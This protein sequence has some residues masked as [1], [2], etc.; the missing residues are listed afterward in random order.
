MSKLKKQYSEPKIY[1]AGGDLTKRWYVY[2]SFRNPETG[3]LERQPTVELGINSFTT[4]KDREEAIILLRKALSYVLKSGQYNPFLKTTPGSSDLVEIISTNKIYTI[5]DAVKFSL[6]IKENTLSENSYSDYRIRVKQFEKWLITNGYEKEPITAIS[7][8]VVTSFLNELL[9]KTSPKNRNNTRAAISQLYG[10]LEDN[11]I[12]PENFITKI[13]V[14]KSKPKRNKTYTT[15]QETAI[16]SEMQKT[17]ELLLLFIKFVSYN[18]LRPVEVARLK[19]KDIDIIDKKIYVSTK[20]KEI[21]IKRIPDILISELPNLTILNQDAWFFTPYG[22]GENWDAKETNRRGTF[23]KRFKIVKDKLG[24]GDEYGMYSWRHT[25]ITKLYNQLIIN[26]TP[27]VAKSELMLITGHTT[28]TAL[29]KYLRD[30]DAVLAEDYSEKIK[31]A[32]ANL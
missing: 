18:F 20:N 28:M 10:V 2:F 31:S 7:K 3:K 5:S 15:T 1:N 25:F 22:Y 30:I 9:K 26:S 24:L 27:F 21:A 19:V 17:D 16:I 6:P 12:I 32:N 14:L 13:S 11:D 4:F 29:E 8:A 23:G